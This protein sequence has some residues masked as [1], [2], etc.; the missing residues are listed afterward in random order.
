VLLHWGVNSRTK[1]PF[2]ADMEGSAAFG[3]GVQNRTVLECRSCICS[4]EICGQAQYG[5]QPG[6]VGE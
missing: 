6:K 4:Q 2:G 3:L 1:P 5:R